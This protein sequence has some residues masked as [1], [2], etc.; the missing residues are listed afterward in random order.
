MAQHTSRVNNIQ[1]KTL[2]NNH[3]YS[4]IN[5]CGFILG[6]CCPSFSLQYRIECGVNHAKR[7]VR[8]DSTASIIIIG[9]AMAQRRRPAHRRIGASA[10]AI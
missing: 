6:Q 4:I 7:F 5:I 1:R 10:P 2:I 3:K 8:L 9:T